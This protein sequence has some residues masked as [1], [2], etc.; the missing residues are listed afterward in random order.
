MGLEKEFK[1]G[2][3]WVKDHLS[4]TLVGDVSTF[5]TTIR[6]LGG[7]ISA[8][9]LSDDIIFL[10]QAEYLA[11]RLFK[12]F[13]SPSGLPR[14][15]INLRTGKSHLSGNGNS[16]VLAE[17]ASLQLEYRYMAKATGKEEYRTK[18]ERVFDILKRITPRDGLMP[19]NLKERRN[20]QAYFSNNVVSFGA[21]GDSAYEYML[22]LWLQGGQK[23]GKYRDLWDKSI[24]GMHHNLVKK[25]SANGLTYIADRSNK[26][27]GNE[28][29]HLVCFIGGALALGAYTDPEG[30]DSPRAERDLRTAKSIAYTCYQMYARSSTGLSPESVVFN[31]CT[32][33]SIS[34]TN[35]AYMLRPEAVETFYYLHKLTGDPIYRVGK[36]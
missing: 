32:D 30:I 13:D 20:G 16:Y 8:Y 31:G 15:R 17:V 7:L 23:E 6:S 27:V 35:P 14:G 4:H 26:H 36:L 29:S 19:L 9:D 12:A 24:N 25:S 33:F 3:D 28:M 22:K 18:S 5:E 21:M 34:K 10:K 2:R 1:E 11:P